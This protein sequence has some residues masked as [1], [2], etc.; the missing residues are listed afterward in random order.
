MMLT[1][2]NRLLHEKI[3]KLTQEHKAFESYVGSVRGKE[4]RERAERRQ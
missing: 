4:G 1:R 2:E 3:N